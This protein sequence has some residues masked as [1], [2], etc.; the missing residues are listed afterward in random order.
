[1]WFGPVDAE[2]L[3]HR[4]RE[5]A[6]GASARWRVAHV[7]LFVELLAVADGPEWREHFASLAA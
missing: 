6:A 3:R 1:M 5:Q 7:G 2:A 4:C